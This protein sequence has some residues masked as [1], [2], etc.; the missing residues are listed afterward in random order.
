PP[1]KVSDGWLRRKRASPSNRALS[2]RIWA[3]AAALCWESLVEVFE[4]QAPDLDYSRYEA[5][6]LKAMLV[7]G[8]CWGEMGERLMSILRTSDN[9]QRLRALVS[10][11]TGYGVADFGRS[12][13]CTAQRV[14]ILGFGELGDGDAHVYSLPL[15]PSLAACRE[16]RRVVVTL[17]WLT[18][19]VVRNQKYRVASMWFDVAGSD[20][21]VNRTDADWRAV[22]R[23]TLQHEVFEGERAVAFVDGDA[24][25]IKVNC[26]KEAGKM[27]EGR[28]R[29]L[30][31]YGLVVSLEVSEGVSIP[32]YDEIRA[33]I[34]VRVP[35]Q[36]PV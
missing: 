22:R 25:A 30:L 5:S 10:R 29:I 4:S 32:I 13:E 34:P 14:S 9:G 6:L 33:R 24:L 7:H 35:V 23:G 28:K 15:P 20:L 17:A 19:T 26:R 3:R 12:L 18:P 21:S 27:K 31:P 11:W 2:I 1:L 8:S 16:W 36:Q